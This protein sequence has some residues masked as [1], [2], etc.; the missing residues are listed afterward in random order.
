MI[1]IY[2]STAIREGALA[3]VFAL[4][5][6]MVYGC[7]TLGFPYP[8]TTQERIAAGYTTAKTLIITGDTLLE[9]QK[10][11]SKDAKNIRQAVEA[12]REGLDIADALQ[13]TDSAGAKNR[14]EVAI[15]S[16]D[17]LEAYLET[18]K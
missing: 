15:A 14:V 4:T 3:I 2:K 8:E 17:A 9:A 6:L 7:S 10:I 16:L 12:G 5:F 1:R 18:R 13:A 11:G